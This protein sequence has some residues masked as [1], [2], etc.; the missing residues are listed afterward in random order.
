MRFW[1]AIRAPT[2][3][4]VYLHHINFKTPSSQVSTSCLSLPHP[5]Q[6]L[7]FKSLKN[8]PCPEAVGLAIKVKA[9]TNSEALHLQNSRFLQLKLQNTR[10]L[11]AHHPGTR[12]NLSLSSL[13]TGSH[14]Q[15]LAISRCSFPAVGCRHR[16]VFG[17]QD[18]FLF[19][20]DREPQPPQ[21]LQVVFC[22][23]F[24]NAWLVAWSCTSKEKSAFF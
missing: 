5:R 4:L 10:N 21:E 3:A 9:D 22:P 2:S 6:I 7:G 23:M 18:K 24:L 17:V 20:A 12:M 15:S 19:V 1:F 13:S 16:R 8:L 11:H 14:T